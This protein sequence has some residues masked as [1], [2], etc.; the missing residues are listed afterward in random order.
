[1]N[2]GKSKEVAFFNLLK[3]LVS[4]NIK[5]EVLEYSISVEDLKEKMFMDKKIISGFLQKLQEDGLLDILEN[6]DDRVDLHFERTHDKV[7]E[8]M[9][10]DDL[11]NII[12]N[13]KDFISRNITHFRFHVSQD[14]FNSYAQESLEGIEK[15][16]P[17]F[18]MS[19][20]I[21]RGVNDIFNREEVIVSVNRK[22]FDICTEAKEEDLEI[23]EG[24]FYCCLNLPPMEN[25]F[26]IT[27]F[28]AKLCFQMEM[29]KR[30][31][32]S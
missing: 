29:S 13:I 7:L 10:V 31:K 32:I 11:D 2:R 25:P 17:A 14:I 27:L 26:Y 28:L 30:E 12:M 19:G 1:M 20:I 3:S 4:P 15:E 18:D 5:N 9:S 24:I 22:L 16:G 21:E 8:F 6:T 23:L